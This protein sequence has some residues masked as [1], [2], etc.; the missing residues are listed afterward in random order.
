M[1]DE[2]DKKVKAK[3]YTLLELKPACMTL[4]YY[5]HVL[6]K[7]RI[8]LDLPE[9][10]SG[11]RVVDVEKALNKKVDPALVDRI[12]TNKDVVIAYKNSSLYNNYEK[13]I[14]EFQN[15][16][17][18]RNDEEQKRKNEVI[19]DLRDEQ[20]KIG[21]TPSYTGANA[22]NYDGYRYT[23]FY[24]NDLKETRGINVVGRASDRVLDLRT[25]RID[26][27]L[28]RIY[29]KIEKAKDRRKKS[30]FKTV[31]YFETK[32]LQHLANRMISLQVKQ[33]RLLDK[34]VEILSKN[35]Q[36][37]I[38]IK[39]RRYG[40]ANIASRTTSAIRNVGKATQEGVDARMG[41]NDTMRM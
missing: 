41:E 4:A 25:S 40:L 37:Y 24:D 18:A 27:K 7:M 23:P 16:V 12:V 11:M 22:K 33:G 36:R 31:K 8:P 34:Q 38:D 17:E 29:G 9:D 3:E 1:A 39:T 20:T 14:I 28:N 5:V 19:K 30:V 10:I 6:K 13:Q 2:K 35:A 15:N 26:N 21:T 32:R